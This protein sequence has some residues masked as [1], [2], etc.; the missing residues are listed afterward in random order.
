MLTTHRPRPAIS[1][2][3]FFPSVNPITIP[4]EYG[5]LP[6]FTVYR[7]RS[8]QYGVQ[9][10]EYGLPACSLLACIP[11]TRKDGTGM[12]EY[13]YRDQA[14]GNPSLLCLISDHF[15][16]TAMSCLRPGSTPPHH[17]QYPSHGRGGAAYLCPSL[18][19]SQPVCVRLA[20][21]LFVYLSGGST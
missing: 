6:G 11:G 14:A 7:V 16:R 4:P 2:S 17:R 19:N 15:T 12:D 13:Q 5:V 9:S 20:T 3:P 18:S 10:T 8:T 21:R 1:I